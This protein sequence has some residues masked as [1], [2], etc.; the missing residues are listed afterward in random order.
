MDVEVHELVLPPALVTVLG[1][2]IEELLALHDDPP[3][4]G[5][6]VWDRL[7]PATSATASDDV[8]IRELVHPD[9]ALSRRTALTEIS[10]HLQTSTATADGGARILFDDEQAVEFLGVVND[11]RLALAARVQP[12]LFTEPETDWPPLTR[13]RRITAMVELVDH[14]AWLQEQLLTSLDPGTQSHDDTHGHELG[15]DAPPDATGQDEDPA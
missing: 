9:L 10:A 7:Y 15:H 5:D 2:L 12:A 13:A 11:V 3:E 8:E 6:P 4:D 14:L 1:R